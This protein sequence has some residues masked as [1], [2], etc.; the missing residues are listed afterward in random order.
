VSHPPLGAVVA[1]SRGVK[2]Y[3]ESFRFLHPVNVHVINHG[4]N[5]EWL[6]AQIGAPFGLRRRLGVAAQALIVAV[7]ANLRPYKR[8]DLVVRATE[9]LAGR[10]V[11]FVHL[12]EDR[13]W[14]AKAE[15]LR[16]LHFL[17]YQ[18]SP[19]S[20]L[21]EADV[22]ATTAHNEAFGRS[23]LEA[24]ALGKPLIGSDAGGLP[25]LIE[26][27]VN[28]RLFESKNAEDFADKVSF[29]EQDR[30]AVEQHS[31]NALDLAKR[32][33]SSEVMADE[34]FSLYRQV[35]E[36][37]RKERGLFAIFVLLQVLIERAAFAPEPTS[38]PL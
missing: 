4:V 26:D 36:S 11:H 25:D 1:V 30:D 28:G 15:R 32:R 13:G 21:D 31:R 22:F 7:M 23:N 34:Y 10:N 18:K 24:M 29:Y 16:N 38:L 6:R 37:F 27:G 14:R 5:G 33:F 12:G 8:F 2:T 20:I 19:W 17:G 3:L 35:L 9:M